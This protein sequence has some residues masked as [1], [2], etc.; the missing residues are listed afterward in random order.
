MYHL[1]ALRRIAAI[2]FVVLL[3][4]PLAPAPNVLA[5]GGSGRQMFLPTLR[6]LP[7][8]QLQVR[9]QPQN[10]N[11][12]F[13][14]RLVGAV[15][16]G[17]T[18][19]KV[20][21]NKAMSPDATDPAL[22]SI[23][24]E[25]A[26]A[27][28]SLL[29]VTSAAFLDEAQTLV[30]LTTF[31]QNEV[32]YRV[33]ASTVHDFWGEP[34]GPKEVVGGILVDP[35]SAPFVGTP[36]GVT[37][38]DTDGDGLSDNAEQYGWPIYIYRTDGTIET[39][40]VT[41][42]PTTNDTDGDG[43]LDADERAYGADPRLPDSDGDQLT[44]YQEL[45]EVYSDPARQ[46][47]DGDLFADGLEYNFFKTSPL[48]ADT[49]GDQL[50]DGDEINSAIRN[51]RVADLPQPSIEVGETK[52][53][54]DVRFTEETATETREL[55]TKSVESTL[56]QSD[57]KEF[58]NMNSN[59]QEAMAKFS[60]GSEFTVKASLTDFG[61]SH[62]ISTQ[63]EAGWTGSWT[64]EHT[65]TSEQQTEQAYQK[66][67]AT[68]AETTEGATVVREVVG[69]QLQASVF[70]RNT[71]N[72]AYSI[73]NL[74][75]TAVLQNPQ[76][77]TR[78]I[79]V[80]TLLPDAEPEEG[81]TL[82]PLSPERGPILFSNDTIFPN[83]VESLM[84]N[85]RGLT[86]VISNFDIT[87]ELGRNFAFSS[88]EVI[89]RTSTLVI[90]KGSFDSDGDGEGDLTEYYRIASNTG[91]LQDT[92]G[93][94]V[95]D[96]NDRRVVFGGDG[97]QI[98]IT[99]A[100][101]LE[102]IG[103]TK[104][105][106]TV[107]PTASLTAEELA[108]S[109]STILI[110][111]A[112]SPTEQAE[113][114][115]RV[116]EIAI[117]DGVPKS[118]EIL[119]PTGIDQTVSTDE[120]IL[121]TEGD[122]KLLFVADIDQD[123]LP[124]NLEYVHN[125]SD[126]LADTDEDTLDDRLETLIGWEVETGRGTRQVFSRCS[127]SDSDRD[128][129]TDDQEAGQS[130]VLCGEGVTPTWV[131]DPSRADTDGDGVPD[132][133]E[134]CGYQVT[135]RSTGQTITVQTN[136][137][138]PDTDGDTAPDGVEAELG[139]NPTDPGDRNQ[140]ADDDGDG[141]VNVGETTTREI[142]IW[143]VS[144]SP[145][146]CNTVC[147][148]GPQTV[149]SVTSD[150]SNPDTDG[151]GLRDGEELQLG[152]DPSN[153][154]TDGDGLTDFEEVHGFEL[155]DQ[156]F[157]TLDPVDADTDNDKLSDGAEVEVVDNETTR[158]I[159]RV[160]GETPYRVF[161]D[162]LQ[163]DADFDTLVDGDERTP[164]TDPNKANTDEDARDD[165]TE[166]IRGTRPLVEDFLVTVGF[167][168]LT[169]IQDCDQP[170]EHA[171]DFLFD[172]GARR[173]DGTY[174]QAVTSALNA[175]SPAALPIGLCPPVEGG[176]NLEANLCR[177]GFGAQTHIRIQSGTTLDLGDRSV[178]LGVARNETISIAGFVQESEIT[179]LPPFTALPDGNFPGSN[180]PFVLDDPFNATLKTSENV[181][182]TATFLGS[183]L[184]TGSLTVG[185]FE[186]RNVCD[187][188]LKVFMQVE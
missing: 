144:N 178:T 88:Q 174:L 98:G 65:E 75:L 70:L 7:T 81:F 187:L 112:G 41:S 71:S 37:L 104:Y 110:P 51:P 136:P 3:N 74:Q 185:V 151:D 101:A 155:R 186:K 17:N 175:T 156:G 140:F 125:C 163:A 66:S 36:A 134:I 38:I 141:V 14:A 102:A 113:R 129:L 19:V 20:A 45:N 21:F 160:V 31:S 13:D 131:T 92:N 162:P 118:W 62:K 145:A 57:R 49:D 126:S 179:A 15:S 168:E 183:E 172:L 106:E 43:I 166:V 143:E 105:D 128:G 11:P 64:S 159:V 173:S 135:L 117:Q 16:T 50:T 115:F 127:L 147:D 152:S 90:D 72:L 28:P 130:P 94:G 23:V 33:T 46:D 171:G 67:L 40:H 137:T 182:R 61:V 99:L 30:E 34:L 97:K 25:H 58:S 12:N 86:F 120:L 83:L 63:A 181:T 68:E 5:Q 158:W 55:E 26:G 176:F 170:E 119:T 39:R 154:D 103:L 6:T 32:V 107:T 84:Q 150:P 180:F 47:S 9:P 93:D 56:T 164:G 153:V 44:D 132:L 184:N 2:V 111:I 4:I 80:A 96:E 77:P 167:R 8:V 169:V 146:L 87:D 89:E 165:A 52:L 121:T 85:P 79:P 24:Q 157:I 1:N 48:F 76:D 142:V 27:D 22:Y 109:Y 78:L 122:I 188:D 149:R 100:D 124:A 91:R 35:T 54:L 60:V 82:G 123:R 148:Q 116:G 161:S 29:T 59:T 108:K 53:R 73:H 10:P 69:A 42:D 133:A 114:I 95:I 18:T 138:N 177:A 139:G